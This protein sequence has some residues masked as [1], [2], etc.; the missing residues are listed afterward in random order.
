MTYETVLEGLVAVWL[1]SP[2]LDRQPDALWRIWGRACYE[3]DIAFL[4]GTIDDAA[5]KFN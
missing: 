1:A 4:C 3:T 5:A 2:V